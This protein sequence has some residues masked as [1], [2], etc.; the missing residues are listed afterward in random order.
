MPLPNLKREQ[1]REIVGS[2]ADQILALLQKLDSFDEAHAVMELVD[3]TL[4]EA[5]HPTLPE[6]DFED[7]D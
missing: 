4:W 2:T 5:E 6:L 1:E 3:E 7:D